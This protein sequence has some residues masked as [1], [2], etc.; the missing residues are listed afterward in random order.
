MA[1][2]K[3]KKGTT[4]ESASA[5]VGEKMENVGAGPAATEGSTGMLNRPAEAGD[6]EHP[7]GQGL[8]PAFPQVWAVGGCTT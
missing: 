8:V 3:L 7:G 6:H 4:G 5:P 1:D 2:G